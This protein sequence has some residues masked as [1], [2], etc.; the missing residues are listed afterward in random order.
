MGNNIGNIRVIFHHLLVV[1]A[2]LVGRSGLNPQAHEDIDLEQPAITIAPFEKPVVGFQEVHI[3]CVLV[4]IPKGVVVVAVQVYPCWTLAETAWLML[5]STLQLLHPTVG[6]TL[7]LH[8]HGHLPPLHSLLLFYP[9]HNY[10]QNTVM[11]GISRESN[12]FCLGRAG[13]SVRKRGCF[14]ETFMLI[15][16]HL[17]CVFLS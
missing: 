6:R 4:D 13:G 3:G 1:A 5:G 15:S 8:L 9:L 12:D 16:K 17:G 11:D 2:T 7:F 14:S 10:Y